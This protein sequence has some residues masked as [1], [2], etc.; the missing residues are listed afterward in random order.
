MEE[1]KS[2]NKEPAIYQDPDYISSYFDEDVIAGDIVNNHNDNDNDNNHDVDV[3]NDNDNNDNDNVVSN[4]TILES[5]KEVFPDNKVH[6]QALYKLYKQA[7]DGLSPQ[8]RKTQANLINDVMDTKIS[9]DL[10]ASLKKEYD[11][12][13]GNTQYTINLPSKITAIVYFLNSAFTYYVWSIDDKAPISYLPMSKMAFHAI[14]SALN[15]DRKLE[16][17]QLFM[18]CIT[19]EFMRDIRRT[20]PPFV[21]TTTME[22]EDVVKKIKD[23]VQPICKKILEQCSKLKVV[24]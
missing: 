23:V 2:E 16:I 1:N 19:D 20:M 15:P 10:G 4:K 6:M 13:A 21:T 17:Y 3:N 7:F 9:L 14:M 5:L 24:S 22:R 18:T 12:L 8:E 11:R